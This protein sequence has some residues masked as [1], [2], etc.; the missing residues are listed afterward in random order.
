MRVIVFG[1][2]GVGSHL[3]YF[4]RKINADT[5]QNIVN[6]VFLVDFDTIEQKNISRQLFSDS[7][8]GSNKAEVS[9]CGLENTDIEFT[10]MKT[11]IT[12]EEQLLF[13]D[14][15]NDLAIICTDNMDSKL[16]IAEYFKN[17][18]IVNCDKDY[19]EIQ[20][21]I[22]ESDTR[23]WGSGGYSSTQTFMSNVLS[24][25][26]VYSNIKTYLV[27]GYAMVDY[28]VKITKIDD[29]LALQNEKV[30]KKVVK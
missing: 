15:E 10:A 11:K 27:F 24:A 25:L 29:M 2:G 28:K 26:A 4:L 6:E 21:V 5:Q 19:Y 13:F 8:V 18:F 12:S 20:N 9:A 3:A 30:N 17:F 14:S 1:I 23:V 22:H 7:S 16:L